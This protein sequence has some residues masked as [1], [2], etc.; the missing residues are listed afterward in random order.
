LFHRPAGWL[1]RLGWGFAILVCAFAIFQLASR[2]VCIALMIIAQLLVPF[3]LVKGR[4]RWLVF[5]AIFFLSLVS[6]SLVR[7]DDHLH[8]RYLLQLKQ[9]LRT[10]TG[11]LLDP[12]PR[13][14]RW[15]CAW[16]AIRMSP[17]IGFGTGAEEGVLKERY[18][19]HHLMISY[20]LGLNAHNQFLSFWLKTG[21]LGMSVYIA[22]LALAFREA[23]RRKDIYLMSF[24]VI[25]T[26]ISLSENILDVNKG[27]FFFSMFFVMLAPKPA[28]MSIFRHGNKNT[29]APV[30]ARVPGYYDLLP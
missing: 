6:V 16:E 5:I 30:G 4:L 11:A 20:K 12:E 21:I 1:I 18:Y 15:Q 23:W 27:I 13:M 24:A 14:V 26:C 17:W 22:L 25:I 29:S 28:A 7:Q 10:D 2:A 3:Y 19:A 8:S 9:D